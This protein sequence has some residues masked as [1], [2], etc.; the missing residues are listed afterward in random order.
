MAYN[1]GPISVNSIGVA[2]AIAPN[3]VQRYW[4]G[5]Q[6]LWVGNR[7]GLKVGNGSS[8]ANPLSSLFGSTGALAKLN[9]TT[10]Q[11]HV[12]FV[13]P[14]HAESVSAADIG[15]AQGAANSFAVVGLGAG[16]SRAA[17]TW[18]AAAGTWLLDTDAITLDNLRLFMAGPTGS[19]TAITVAAAMTVSGNGC[20][21]RN[22]YVDCGVDADQIITLGVVVTGKRLTF[23]NNF[24][25]GDPTAEITAAGAFMRLTGADQAA[26]RNNYFSLANATVTDGII[27]TLTTA[28]LDLT[29]E[30]NYFNSS[31]VTST[32]AIDF[33]AA[34]AT[35][36]ELRRNLLKV[37]ADGTAGSVVFTVNAANNVG[38][39]DN[40]MVN[41]VNERGLV[42]GT[43][44]T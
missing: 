44:S 10:S 41:N 20:A 7:S 40:F 33:G 34:I 11:G 8:P 9:A 2:N 26:I 37:G 12:I 32:C 42:I 39:L 29:I 35:T 14:G 30:D 13:L 18:T 38:L 31:K 25:H 36:G 24:V 3:V 5:G 27:E 6:I 21:I 1:P 17:F 22:C 28:S 16:E 19:T 23:E 4:G 15:S 43:A